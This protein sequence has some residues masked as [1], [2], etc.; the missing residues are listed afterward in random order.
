[1]YYPG[2]WIHS[3]P[4][5]FHRRQRR[6]KIKA[7]GT[8]QKGNRDGPQETGMDLGLKNRK[9]FITGASR[10]IGRA[11]AFALA[12]EGVQVALFGRDTPRCEAVAGELR[13]KHAG[14]KAF[15]VWHDFEKTESK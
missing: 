15:A 13:A 4:Q 11:I 1:M 12:T 8:K 7:Q 5:N 2:N 3:F 10:G 9:A 14:Q 6:V